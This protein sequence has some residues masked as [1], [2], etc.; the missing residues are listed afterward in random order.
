MHARAQLCVLHIYVQHNYTVQR[1]IMRLT[2]SE[3]CENQSGYIC[4]WAYNM[5]CYDFR[6]N[7]TEMVEN[8]ASVVIHGMV[9]AKTR[10]VD[11]TQPVPY[12][13]FTNKGI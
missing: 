2:L 1:E 13:V 3:K 8:V 6:L 11:S 7:T 10:L 4:N 12:P 5:V 9:H